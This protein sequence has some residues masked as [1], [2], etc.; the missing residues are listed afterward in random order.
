MITTPSRLA[1]EA[2]ANVLK[3]GGNAIEAVVAAA[4]VL[5]V[6]Y[7]HFCGLGGDAVW[8]IAGEAGEP[9]SLLGIGQAAA[10]ARPGFAPSVRGAG[11]TL[12]SAGLVDSWGR[13]LS[14]SNEHWDGTHALTDLLVPA[15]GY[16][17]EGFAMSPSQRFWLDMRRSEL[18]EWPGFSASFL[19][20]G[21]VPEVGWHF[22]QPALADTLSAIAEDG[23]R[24]FYEGRL[25]KRIAEGLTRAGSPLTAADLAATRSEFST[26]I[27]VRYRDI[28]LYAPP[29]P[30]QGLATLATM[31][32]LD[33][34]ELEGLKE[35][36]ADHIHLV[37][38][39][40]KQAFLH[41]GKIA[42]QP[43]GEA[44]LETLLSA[45][46]LDTMAAAIDRDRAL[47]WPYPRKQGDTVYIGA[48]DAKGR[49][50]SM[51]QSTYFDW[52][53]GVVVGDTGIIWHNRGAAFSSDPNHP[54][55]VAPGKRPFHTL[56]PGLSMEGGRPC[57]LYGTQGADGQ[58]Q[59]LALLLTRLLAFGMSPAE[60]LRGPR[61]LLGKTFSNQADSLKIEAD[62]GDTVLNDLQRRGHDLVVT[63]AQNPLFGQAGVIRI[64]PDGSLRGAHDPRSDGIALTV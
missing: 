17:R 55:A 30:S 31:G 1:S 57:L 48:V 2:G 59:T 52:G 39:A 6:V 34:I 24:S 15:I 18:A 42:D 60:A 46:T 51:L 3:A 5:T 28:D 37:I 56:N 49:C 12:T 25:A 54:N 7:P 13:A 41:R 9:T 36:G 20:G 26:P 53:S 21:A 35:S 23:T 33:R 29:P 45:P 8:M 47:P 44:G 22:R 64:A 27:T 32:I 4:A 10:S 40:I 43:I 11:S 58:P 61:F 14:H 38:E 50:V 63:E 16:A 62:F 19:D